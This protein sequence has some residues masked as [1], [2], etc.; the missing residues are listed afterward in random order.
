MV[1]NLDVLT[2]RQLTEL[3]K[4]LNGGT[5]GKDPEQMKKNAK[6]AYIQTLA[7]G[8][9]DSLEAADTLLAQAAK[10]ILA[11]VKAESDETIG[12]H[13]AVTTGVGA[14][15]PSAQILDT[16][17]EPPTP[18]G[19][20]FDGD[21]SQCSEHNCE[22]RK[23]MPCP[24]FE[25]QKCARSAARNMPTP[26]ITKPAKTAKSAQS[27]SSSTTITGNTRHRI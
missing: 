22:Y 27:R 23:G 17:G 2:T 18:N 14:D 19:F 13:E 12:G 3:G 15:V 6:I 1:Y 10:S 5:F 26:R 8:A 16:E 21:P 4:R 24:T 11:G 7:I 20:G 25:H 9:T